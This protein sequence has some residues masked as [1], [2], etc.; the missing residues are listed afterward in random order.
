MK[1]TRH[2]LQICLYFCVDVRWATLRVSSTPLSHGV[3][4]RLH[5]SSES[6]RQE[7]TRG[8]CDAWR[9]C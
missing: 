7:G 3:P 6:G 4:V 2:Y 1:V 9:V 5:R 8:V